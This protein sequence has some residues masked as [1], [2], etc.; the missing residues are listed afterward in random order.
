MV[1]TELIRDPQKRKERALEKE[2]W[3]LCFLHNEI[4]SSTAIL[5]REMRVGVRAARNV[6]NRMEKKGYIIRDE[7]KFMGSKALPLWGITS[8]GIMNCIDPDEVR[9]ASLRYHRPGSV[10]PLTIEHTLDVQ[11]CQQYFSFVEDSF[12]WTPTRFMPGHSAK[13]RSTLRW[14][15]YPD[16]IVEWQA[17]DG[18]DFILSAVEVERSRKTPARYVQIIRG[19]L[20]NIQEDRY[21]EVRYYCP[22]Q[23]MAANLE[24]LFFRLIIQKK[25]QA[26]AHGRIYSSSECIELFNFE[27]MEVFDRR[28]GG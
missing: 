17:E 23:K 16:G 7:V 26:Y 14:P 9:S 3:A 20:R 13:R 21:A 2:Q 12:D 5:A 18:G 1:T 8:C 24:A 27:S 22:T 10:S 28:E 11:R 19:H 4:Y 25:I 15:V 6:L